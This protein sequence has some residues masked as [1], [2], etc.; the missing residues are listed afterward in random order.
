VDVAHDGLQKSKLI[1]AILDS[2]KF[3]PSTIPEEAPVVTSSEPK[4]ESGGDRSDG[5]QSRD[6]SPEP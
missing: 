6:G 3:D 2:E 1:D 5:F 4:E